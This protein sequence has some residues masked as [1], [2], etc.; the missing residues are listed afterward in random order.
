MGP[1]EKAGWKEGAVPV[2][3]LV[4]SVPHPGGCPPPSG[5]KLSSVAS[6]API[7]LHPLGCGLHLGRGLLGVE[8]TEQDSTSQS[9]SSSSAWSSVGQNGWMGK[10]VLCPVI[11]GLHSLSPLPGTPPP[12]LHLTPST[13]CPAPTVHLYKCGAMRESCGLC[14]KA[15]PD[16]ECGW[17]QGQAQCTLRQHCP[18]HE[19]QW[20]ELSGANSKCTNPRITEV[21]LAHWAHSGLLNHALLGAGP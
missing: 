20:L 11:P 16:F 10:A 18:I 21:S 6:A 3:R 17:C 4:A 7:T 19:S 13:C 5:P 14:L 9:S 12:A 15:D 8:R 2:H 1:G